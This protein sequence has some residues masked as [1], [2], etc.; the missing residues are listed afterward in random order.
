MIHIIKKDGNLSVEESEVEDGRLFAE[1][2]RQNP[3]VYALH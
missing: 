1:T 3:E 2:G